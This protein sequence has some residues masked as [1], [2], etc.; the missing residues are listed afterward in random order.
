MLGLGFRGTVI[1]LGCVIGIIHEHIRKVLGVEEVTGIDISETGIEVA[2]RDYP[3]CRFLCQP[4]DDLSNIPDGE[5]DVIHGREF[6]PFTRTN[7]LDFQIDCLKGYLPKLST[8]GAVILSM[9]SLSKGFCTNWVSARNRLMNEGY[10]VVER[11][12]LIHQAIYRK[13]GKACYKQPLNVF[14]GIIQSVMSF[15]LNKKQRY[16]YIMVR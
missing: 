11:R 4:A 8:G 5:T 2:R 9:V 7:D 6:Y 1:D 13:L 14:L 12:S 16:V 10:S 15:V 3:Q